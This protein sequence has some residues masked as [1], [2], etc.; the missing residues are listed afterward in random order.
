MSTNKPTLKLFYS[1]KNIT[2]DIAS[3]FLRVEF[4][5]HLSGESDTLEVTLSDING[6]W[7]GSWY[8][9]HGATLTFSIGYENEPLLDCGSFEIDEI[10]VMDSP[11]K[12]MIRAL[13][14]GVTQTLRTRKYRAYDDKTLDQVINQVASEIGFSVEGR[15]TPIKIARLTQKESDLSFIKRLSNAYGYGVKVIG[16]R[17]VFTRLK[18]MRQ[19]PAIATIDRTDMKPN[20]QFT[21]QIRTVKKQANVTRH[22]PTTKKTVRASVDGTTR[23]SADSINS[24]ANSFDAAQAKEKADAQLETANDKKAESS[25]S[26]AGDTRLTAG[27]NINITGMQRF[28]GKYRI[29]QATHSISKSGGY[30]TEV[31]MTRIS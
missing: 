27:S 21:E 14:A 8:P 13:S 4:I 16:K 6:Y 30:L 10:T 15:I 31:Q 29:K 23:S 7:R 28:D 22:N 11:N 2:R 9:D 18:L 3:D 17:L 5:D 19:A 12:V 1:N 25:F 24:R 20:W 26:I